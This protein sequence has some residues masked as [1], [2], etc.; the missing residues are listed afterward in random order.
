M[1]IKN[2]SAKDGWIR[3]RARVA[4]LSTPPELAADLSAPS[5]APAK[6]KPAA[7]KPT[8]AKR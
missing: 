1:T 4:A 8:K 6:K 7:K 2:E 3:E 5:I